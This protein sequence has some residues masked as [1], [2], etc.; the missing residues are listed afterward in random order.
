MVVDQRGANTPNLVGTHR[1]ADAAAGDRHPAIH[2]HADHCLRQRDHI[3]GIVIAF[4]QSMG[5]KID[6]LMSCV[7]KMGNQLLLQ[8]K[9]TMIRGNSNSHSLSFVSGRTSYL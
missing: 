6:N 3:V 1:R 5:T 9:S 4:A 2:L 8:A 7:A